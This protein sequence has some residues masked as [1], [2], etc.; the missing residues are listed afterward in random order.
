MYNVSIYNVSLLVRNCYYCYIQ[1]ITFLTQFLKKKLAYQWIW[2]YPLMPSFHSSMNH[3]NVHFQTHQVR[4][5]SGIHIIC[6]FIYSKFQNVPLQPTKASKCHWIF[7]FPHRILPVFNK[8]TPICTKASVNI[9]KHFI[10]NWY[11]IKFI[12][13]EVQHLLAHFVTHYKIASSYCTRV[14]T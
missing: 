5:T 2:T 6:T 13:H 14:T 12:K 7:S 1:L 9:S 3:L 8:W 4:S 11:T 10:N